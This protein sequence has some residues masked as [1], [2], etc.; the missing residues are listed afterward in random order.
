MGEYFNNLNIFPPWDR[1]PAVS[2]INLLIFC[3]LPFYNVHQTFTDEYRLVRS[4]LF[5]RA[6]IIVENKFPVLSKIIG[7][8]TPR[9][10]YSTVIMLP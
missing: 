2:K 6:A 4:L 7:L 8:S 3:Q 10:F 1:K 5:L 9:H